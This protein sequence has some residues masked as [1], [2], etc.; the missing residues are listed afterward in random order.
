MNFS[1]I[2]DDEIFKDVEGYEGRYS[3]SN[4]R[5]YSHIGKGRFL[6][7]YTDKKNGYLQVGLCKNG[8]LKTN[9]IHILV[10]NAFVGKRKDEMTFDHID[11]N[12]L[13]NK[14]C[15]LRLATKSEQVINRNILKNNK[16][17]EKNICIDKNKYYFIN[18]KRN[19]KKMFYKRL[20]IDK[21]SLDDAVKI[22]DEFLNK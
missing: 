20:H 4:G 6:K 7:P 16:L 9:R 18:I 11:R 13:N 5:V 1:L 3:V 8:K 17:G 22:R 21:F 10:G 2:A 15:N 19:G 12:K 14:A